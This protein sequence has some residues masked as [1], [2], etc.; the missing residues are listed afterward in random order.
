[1]VV[2]DTALAVWRS[3]SSQ[4][5]LQGSKYDHPYFAI[6]R[7]S[8]LSAIMNCVTLKNNVASVC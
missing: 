6:D 2:L 3:M 5:A 4:Y 7:I 1:M 8:F